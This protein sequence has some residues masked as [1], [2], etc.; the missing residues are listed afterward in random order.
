[1]PKKFKQTLPAD[2]NCFVGLESSS[3]DGIY[4]KRNHTNFTSV[5]QN[6]NQKLHKA[7]CGMLTYGAVFVHGNECPHRTARTRK[8]LQYF[9]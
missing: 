4:T 2:G 8:L 3:D 5:L 6:T 9:N 1:M 7:M